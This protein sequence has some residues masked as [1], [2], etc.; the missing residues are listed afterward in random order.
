MLRPRTNNFPNFT[1]LLAF[2][3]P[4]DNTFGPRTSGWVTL[5][6]V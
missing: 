1:F 5:V 6:L 4:F 2:D 3:K